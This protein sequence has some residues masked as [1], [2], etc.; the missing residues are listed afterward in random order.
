MLKPLVVIKLGGSALTDKNRMFTPRIIEIH[1]AAS[2]LAQLSPKFSL[3]VVHGAGSYGHIPVKT[4]HLEHGFTSRSQLEG[5]AAT[6]GRLLEW[7]SKFTQVFLKHHVPLVPVL[8]SDFIITRNGRIT[9]AN[10]QPLQNLLNLGC[11]PST[12]GDIVSDLS[13][14]FAVLSGDQ[15]AAYLAIKMR[16]SHLIFGT[17]VDGIFNANPKHTPTAVLLTKLTPDA[18]LKAAALAEAI[19]TPD[20]TGGMAGKIREATPAASKG[21]TV[22][23]INL[24]KDR[25]LAKAMLSQKTTG[26]VIQAS[27]YAFMPPPLPRGSTRRKVHPQGRA[28]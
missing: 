4:W 2:Q 21:I 6:K 1:R 24:T 9:S 10:L 22:Q 8:A 28:T 26:T 15:L 23:F 20:V 5:L 19:D 11:V 27:R 12:G 18:A 13:R 17:D 25:R 16:A 14:G 7:E 3:I